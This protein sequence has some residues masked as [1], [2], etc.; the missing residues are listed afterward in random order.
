MRISLGK[1]K[2]VVEI[3]LKIKDSQE[4]KLRKFEALR[5]WCAKEDII[6]SRKS[7]NKIINKWLTTGNVCDRI[8]RHYRIFR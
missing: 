4:F 6:C 2:R 7:L 5:L 1:R 8:S 3:Y